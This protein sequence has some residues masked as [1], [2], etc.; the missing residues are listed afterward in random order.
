MGETYIVAHNGTLNYEGVTSSYSF[1]H[2]NKKPLV[3]TVCTNQTPGYLNL[4]ISL[5]R[6]GYDYAVFGMGQKWGSWPWRTRIYLAILLAISEGKQFRGTV[7]YNEIE[8]YMKRIPSV[9]ESSIVDSMLFP[10][11][12]ITNTTLSPLDNISSFLINPV[13]GNENTED[14]V[15]KEDEK[16]ITKE[17]LYYSTPRNKK[18]ERIIILVDANDLV[19]VKSPEQIMEAFHQ[20]GTPVVIGAENGCCSGGYYPKHLMNRKTVMEKM[21]SLQKDNMLRYPNGG[22]VMGYVKALIDLLYANINIKDDQNGYLE[23]RYQNPRWYALDKNTT[24]VAT[25]K[26]SSLFDPTDEKE[27]S[28][29]ELWDVD[30]PT[31]PTKDYPWTVKVVSRITNNSPCIVHFAGN[32]WDKYNKF[33]NRLLGNIHQPVIVNST[34]KQVVLSA[35]KKS[36]AQSLKHI[37]PGQLP[38]FMGDNDRQ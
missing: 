22:C 9:E 7:P 5:E 27:C 2:T 19:F 26:H 16:D 29:V 28:G 32:N 8:E 30:I 11:E 20:Y 14:D 35:W 17:H 24:I 23:L 6:L 25:I 15:D 12:N 3:V 33:C 31:T 36:W 34:V 10:E 37:V 1:E 38:K 21:F 18:E 4:I 13:E